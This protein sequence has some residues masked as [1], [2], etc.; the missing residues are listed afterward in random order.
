MV[1]A[2]SRVSLGAALAAALAVAMAPLASADPAPPK[3][4][5]AP[6]A[7]AAG[8]VAAAA[9]AQPATSARWTAATPDEM[10]DL[11]FAR[12]SKG[13]SDALAALIVAASLDE[14]AEYGR[15]LRG[16]RALAASSSP[17]AD[18]ARWVAMRHAPDP[19]P[20]TSWP[21]AA[22]RANVEAPPDADGL[23]KA[24]A[25]LGPFQDTGGG[26]M[27]REGPEAE[28]QSWSDAS[29]RYA[30]GAFDVAWRRALPDSSTSRGL[31]LDL[32]ISPRGESCTYVASRVE[33]PASP[34]AVVVH[35][36]ASG[37]VRLIWDG[38]DVAAQEEQH[39][40]LSLDR[41]AARIEAKPGDHL[42][43]V[44]VCTG[45]QG[46]EGRV[47][48]RFTDEA[49]KPIAIPSSSDLTPLALPRS[50]GGGKVA[51]A[52]SAKPKHTQAKIAPPPPQRV[53]TKARTEAKPVADAKQASE[54]RPTPE[55]KPVADAKPVG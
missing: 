39:G 36:G 35:V 44:K 31:P 23:V 55:A 33:L 25:I 2:S 24:F 51:V 26:L 19:M 45:A 27:R 46:D 50:A 30:W 3:A 48:L 43:A 10:V 54:P 52:T 34:K 9:A 42:V 41:M 37:Q 14:R 21:G 32:Y 53:D 5:K 28:G 17:I 49:N 40:H 4:H 7:A 16:L 18:E 22:S 15:V 8:V 6:R 12:A 29:A 47:R 20:K 13:G 1:S 11:A 38:A